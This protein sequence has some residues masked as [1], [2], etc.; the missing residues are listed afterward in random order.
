MLT[1]EGLHT[2]GKILVCMWLMAVH[3]LLLPQFLL[4][5]RMLAG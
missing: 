4:D 5:G 3:L 1:S 2:T